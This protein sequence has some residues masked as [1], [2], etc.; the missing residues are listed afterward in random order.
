MTRLVKLN[1]A[2]YLFA[3][4]D[5]KEISMARAVPV[6]EKV[7]TFVKDQIAEARER[8]TVVEAEAEKVAT[9]AEKAAHKAVKQVTAR[10][11]KVANTAEKAAEKAVKD[12]RTTAKKGQKEVRTLLRGNKLLD[13]G[14]VRELVSR[15]QGA[16]GELLK[17]V[18]QLQTNLFK[19]SGVATVAELKALSRDVAKLTRKVD[20][21]L[22]SQGSA[23]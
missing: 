23:Q 14:P 19:V 22:K 2:R 13:L 3:A 17:S 12:I 7:E 11:N 18:Q 10:A 1:A 6:A 20:A 5:N 16:G 21:L 9:K 8:L 15:A 4:T